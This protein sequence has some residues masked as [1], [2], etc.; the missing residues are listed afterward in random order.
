MDVKIDTKEIT[1]TVGICEF[2]HQVDG[3]HSLSNHYWIIVH[4]L[5]QTFKNR[6]PNTIKSIS[7]YLVLDK[8]GNDLL[9]GSVQC[10]KSVAILLISW[11]CKFFREDIVPVILTINLSLVRDD[12]IGKASS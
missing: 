10:G 4:D 5:W 1:K 12:F 11:Y 8:P 2:F 9:Y 6:Y 7:P 3:I